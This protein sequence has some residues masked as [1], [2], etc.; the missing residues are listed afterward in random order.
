MGMV[1]DSRVI[2]RT[3]LDIVEDL[4]SELR[5]KSARP[6]AT[7]DASLD[8]DLGLGSLER[9]ELLLRLQ[10]A[11]GVLL[12][13]ATM[14]EA[15]TPVRLTSHLAD[16]ALPLSEPRIPNGSFVSPGQVRRFPEAVAATASASAC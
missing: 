15:E 10:Q 7:L 4:V 1:S 12:A 14:E 6:I 3:I 5:G 2:E 8:R 13:D 9:V 16:N 11:F